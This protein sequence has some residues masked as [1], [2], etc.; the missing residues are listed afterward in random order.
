LRCEVSEWDRI[1]CGFVMRAIGRSNRGQA[2]LEAARDF[3]PADS[4][5]GPKPK[6][7]ASKCAARSSSNA[8]SPFRAPPHRKGIS[9]A[10]PMLRRS[11]EPSDARLSLR[12]GGLHSVLLRRQHLSGK[13]QRGLRAAQSSGPEAHRFL[14]LNASRTKR[15]PQAIRISI[16]SELAGSRPSGAPTCRP[17]SLRGRAFSTIAAKRIRFDC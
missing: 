6:S 8:F 15:R 11:D 13:R 12:P 10:S 17:R 16:T 3:S 7:R 5:P 9:D 14:L 2:F 4:R 1:S